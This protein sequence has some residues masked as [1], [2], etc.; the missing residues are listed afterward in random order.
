MRKLK[1]FHAPPPP[2]TTKQQGSGER[3]GGNEERGKK[4]EGDGTICI[5]ILLLILFDAPRY[6][7]PFCLAHTPVFPC[8][9]LPAC[10][11]RWK[12]KDRTNDWKSCKRV[13][14]ISKKHRRNVLE[15]VFRLLIRQVFAS[16]LT[17]DIGFGHRFWYDFDTASALAGE[18]GDIFGSIVSS[19]NI[20]LLHLFS[21]VFPASILADSRTFLCG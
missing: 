20:N 7:V 12:E 8:T 18:F 13:A 6:G 19:L 10:T 4:K 17:L 2:G 1:D 21:Q 3:K 5:H 14:T 16:N 15:K 9:F 11:D